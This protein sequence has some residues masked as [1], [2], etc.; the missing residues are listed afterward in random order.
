MR[1]FLNKLVFSSLHRCGWLARFFS[2][3][4]VHE[5]P[6]EKTETIDLELDLVPC[7]HKVHV[8]L[9][10]HGYTTHGIF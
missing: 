1:I 7:F 6:E 3:D 8:Q 5:D 9:K 4:F 2:L 10:K